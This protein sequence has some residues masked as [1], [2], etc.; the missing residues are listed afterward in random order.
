MYECKVVETLIG[1][2]ILEIVNM[3][4]LGTDSKEYSDSIKTR[5]LSTSW[6]NINGRKRG[7]YRGDCNK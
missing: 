5:N 7:F 6:V 4:E 3:I 2:Y 1:K